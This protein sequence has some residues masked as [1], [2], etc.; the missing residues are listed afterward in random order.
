MRELVDRTNWMRRFRGDGAFPVVK[1]A[2]I[3]MNTRFG[4]RDRPFFQIVK[5]VSLGDDKAVEAPAEQRAIEQA[6][7]PAEVVES[8][9][10]EQSKPSVESKPATKPAAKPVTKPITISEPTLEEI[11]DDALPDF[12]K[13]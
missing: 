4:G 2:K 6:K 8:T 9:K 11:L 3:Y 1:L 12:D 5:W 7:P 10:I 13:K